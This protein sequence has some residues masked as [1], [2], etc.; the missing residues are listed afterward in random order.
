MPASMF[1]MTDPVFDMAFK[2]Q[3][4]EGRLKPLAILPPGTVVRLVGVRRW[5]DGESGVQ[6][7]DAR[8]EVTLPQTG[9]KVTF[10]F[11]WEGLPSDTIQ[12]APWDD[13]S[14]PQKRYVGEDGESFKP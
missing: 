11:G 9:E 10:V 2:R 4:Q 13:D 5:W 6:H 12:R 8:G 7:F 1:D 3:I 14:V